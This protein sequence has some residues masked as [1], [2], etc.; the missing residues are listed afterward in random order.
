ME[1]E[2]SAARYR[3]VHGSTAGNSPSAAASSKNGNDGQDRNKKKRRRR[4]QSSTKVLTSQSGLSINDLTEDALMA[5]CEFL[6]RTSRALFAIAMTAPS[7]AWRE[8]HTA[9]KQV[10]VGRAS[11]AIISSTAPRLTHS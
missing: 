10:I 11:Q 9:G 6:P 2:E 5:V 4:K 8:K 7:S 3:Y 1:N